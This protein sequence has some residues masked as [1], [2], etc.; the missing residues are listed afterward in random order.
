MRERT[1]RLTVEQCFSLDVSELRRAGVFRAHPGTPC[2]KTWADEDGMATFS[3][4]FWLSK[5]SEDKLSLSL[6]NRP[7][8][9]LLGPGSAPNAI[10]EIDFTRCTFG[11]LRR[12]FR[13]P[14]LHG[15]NPCRRRVRVLYVPP[16]SHFWACRQCYSLT[17]DSCQQSDK[18]LN[19]MARLSPEEY[20]RILAGNDLKLS[21]LAI[22]GRHLFTKRIKR[23]LRKATG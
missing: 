15:G 21:L 4:G 10:I 1:S 3:V 9:R 5:Q 22:R 20:F 7:E 2:K 6:V 16:G 18:R 17:Y 13:C 14:G 19:R 12:W 11:G 23:R 8:G